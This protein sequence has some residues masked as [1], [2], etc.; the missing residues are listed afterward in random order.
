MKKMTVQQKEYKSEEVKDYLN[1]ILT[2]KKLD[3]QVYFDFL[4][5][6]SAF[7]VVEL[8][9]FSLRKS[10]ISENDDTIFVKGV[11]LSTSDI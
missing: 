8:I 11:F 10:E 4:S 2:L 5:W 1:D 6:K 9:N 7:K 3:S